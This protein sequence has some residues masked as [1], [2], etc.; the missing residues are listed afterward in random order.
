MRVEGTGSDVDK[1]ASLI[2][3]V[4][5]G[6]PHSCANA[7]PSAPR[8]TGCSIF[9]LNT[10]DSRPTLNLLGRDIRH[11]VNTDLEGSIYVNGLR[12]KCFR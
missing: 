8:A 4:C 6:G 9:D 3:L 7:I 5:F 12:M 11:E 2:E 1:V 10:I